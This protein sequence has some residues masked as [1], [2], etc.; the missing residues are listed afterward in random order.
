MT[1]SSSRSSR[2]LLIA[3]FL[4]STLLIVGCGRSSDSDAPAGPALKVDACQLFTDKDAQA[5]AGD[6]LAGMSSTLDEAQGRNPLECIYNSG[7]L[8]QPRIL[9][10]LIRPHRGTAK[11]F[12]ESSRSSLSSMSG[13][14][15]QDVPG[16]GDS[17]LW[18]GGRLQQLHVATGNLQ[19]IITVHSLDGTDQLPKA[20]Q[21]ATLALERLKSAPKPTR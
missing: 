9:S 8:D 3:P 1:I 15:V 19:L 10:L 17:A 20:R 18:V 14:K 11:D 21:I 12:L 16:L 7:T 5:I 6:T 2:R 4:L 13:G